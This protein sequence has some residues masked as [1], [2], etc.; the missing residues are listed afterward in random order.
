MSTKVSVF[1]QETEMKKD[2]KKIEFVK[3]ISLNKKGHL[4][5]S[6]GLNPS[7]FDNVQLFTKNSSG[8]LCV[9]IAWDNAGT[10][11]QRNVFIGHWNDG[12]V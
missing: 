11:S 2:L 10:I 12:I 6:V 3:R 5:N 4:E 8:S 1:G 7:D 9:I